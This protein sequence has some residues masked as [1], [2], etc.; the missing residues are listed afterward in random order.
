MKVLNICQMLHCWFLF[1]CKTNI[2]CALLFFSHHIVYI[3]QLCSLSG[4]LILYFKLGSLGFFSPLFVQPVFLLLNSLYVDIPVHI[5]STQH[6]KANHQLPTHPTVCNDPAMM[7]HFKVIYLR[8][9]FFLFMIQ[10]LLG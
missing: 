5:S 1:W 6:K 8:L 9:L 3:L 4:F 7:D 10:L 2:F